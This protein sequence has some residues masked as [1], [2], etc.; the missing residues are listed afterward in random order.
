MHQV[1]IQLHILRLIKNHVFSHLSTSG[2][3]QKQLISGSNDFVGHDVLDTSIHMLY[4]RHDTFQLQ[5]TKSINTYMSP[6]VHHLP[7]YFTFI[8]AFINLLDHK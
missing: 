8:Y 6:E 5:Q 7:L 3:F 4:K 2:N 1:G